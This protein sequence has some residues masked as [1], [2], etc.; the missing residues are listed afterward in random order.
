MGFIGYQ[1]RRGPA[2]EERSVYVV[3]IFLECR[4]NSVDGN[5]GAKSGEEPRSAIS[6]TYAVD[7]E[8]P[9][10]NSPCRFQ[11][12]DGVLVLK[13]FYKLVNSLEE[14]AREHGNP[15][16][17]PL[18]SVEALLEHLRYTRNARDLTGLEEPSRSA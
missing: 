1:V 18:E 13:K 12:V 15:R 10:G 2:S 5:S 3:R 17:M 11:G 16:Q 8:F 14:R 6:Y 9:S 7:V 4:E